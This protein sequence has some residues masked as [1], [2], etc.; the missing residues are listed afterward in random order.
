LVALLSLTATIMVARSRKVIRVTPGVRPPII[1]LSGTRS[2]ACIVQV[3]KL[4]LASLCLPVQ[5]SQDRDL[6]GAG[7]GKH[8]IAMQEE[9]P[10]AAE[11]ENS[12]SKHA[13]E[14]VIH[15]SN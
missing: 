7:L 8:F 14:I 12:N 13:I 15:V 9:F 1:S 10:A 6:D 5:L 11:I 2:F 3:A 4:Q